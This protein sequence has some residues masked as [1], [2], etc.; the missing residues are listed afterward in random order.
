[1]FEKIGKVRLEKNSF[2]TSKTL[3]AVKLKTNMIEPEE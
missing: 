1:M 2:S 3:I